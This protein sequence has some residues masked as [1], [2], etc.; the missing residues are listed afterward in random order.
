MEKNEIIDRK[1]LLI[2]FLT[3]FDVLYGHIKNGKLS[4]IKD[5]W[6]SMSNMIGKEIFVH[7]EKETLRGTVEG[8]DDDG[9][10]LVSD[11]KGVKRIVT[12]DISYI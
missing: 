3:H 4:V 2:S 12:G 8:M 6:V 10:L 11:R 5:K 1:N 7:G 9:C